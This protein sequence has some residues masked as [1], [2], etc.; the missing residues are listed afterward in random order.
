ME[1]EDYMSDIF[2]RNVDPA[3]VK[4]ID[5][6]DGKYYIHQYSYN[7]MNL[8]VCSTVVVNDGGQ[9]R[10]IQTVQ[11][12]NLQDNMADKLLRVLLLAML[13]GASLSFI[14]G[15]FIA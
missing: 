3:A 13:I 8:R 15:Y 5:E 2:I 11:N 6:T 4:T 7:D 9:M 12:M 1:R 10:I 14:S